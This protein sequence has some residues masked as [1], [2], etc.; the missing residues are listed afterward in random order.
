MSLVRGSN[1]ALSSSIFF[2]SSSSS[3]SRPSLVVL[4]NFFPSNSLSCTPLASQSF[5]IAS[6]DANLPLMCDTIKYLQS[7]LASIFFSRSSTW[8]MALGTAVNVK[9]FVRTLSPCC[10]PAHLSMRKMAEPQ[11]LRPTANLWPVKSENSFSTS[12]TCDSSLDATLYL[13]N[14]PLSIVLMTS[15]IPSL[16]TGSGILMF[17]RSRRPPI[18]SDDMAG[19]TAAQ[20]MSLVLHVMVV[21]VC[22]G[23]LQ[24][25]L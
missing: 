16:G 24:R 8:T 1:S 2:F 4:F 14:L 23:V 11:L 7:G 21:F 20:S 9:P 19:S 18:A 6:I 22:L 12:D 17:F 13:N 3:I 15:S 10:A 25:M 5:L